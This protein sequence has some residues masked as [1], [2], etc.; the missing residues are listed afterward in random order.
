MPHHYTATVEIA[1]PLADL[2]TFLTKPKNFAQLAP[3]DLNLELVTAP[4]ELKLGSRLV[5]KGRRWGISAQIIHEVTVF[6]RD[7]KIVMEQKEGVLARWVYTST[8]S[9]TDLG[10]KFVET[11]DFDP[12]GGMLGYLVTADSVRKDMEKL[13]NF[14]EKKLKEMFG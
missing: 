1:H 11:I 3:A 12:P 14:R 9:A 10:T 5:W 2:F 7:K 6:E 13:L 4:D 8:F